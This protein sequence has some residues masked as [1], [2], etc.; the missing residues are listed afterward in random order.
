MCTYE[1]NC[2]LKMVR[3]DQMSMYIMCGLTVLTVHFKMIT[4]QL[5]V[6][7]QVKCAQSIISLDERYIRD[8]CCEKPLLS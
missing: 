1:I 8:G 5:S 6:P 3:S 4:E 7:F 2:A